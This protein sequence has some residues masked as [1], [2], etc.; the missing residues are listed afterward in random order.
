MLTIFLLSLLH[1]IRMH[2]HITFIITYT[3]TLLFRLSFSTV[4]PSCIKDASFLFSHASPILHTL[5]PTISISLS[6]IRHKH[7]VIYTL[8]G[9]LQNVCFSISFLP[10]SNIPSHPGFSYFLSGFVSK[11]FF[12]RF[13]KLC[14]RPPQYAPP[15]ASW[16]LSFWPWK[17]CPSHVWR[18][19]PLC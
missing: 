7:F 12:C 8:C 14:G 17:W 19:L 10:P 15:P 4:T 5:H 16:P 1:L 11:C 3:W 6:L 18:G 9:L 2:K 13:N